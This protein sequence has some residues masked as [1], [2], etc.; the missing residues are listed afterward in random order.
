MFALNLPPYE[1]NIVVRNG[2]K[3]IFDVLR[4]NFV[5][6]TPEEWVR[7]HFIHY[8]LDSK[9]YP[10][11]LLGNEMS[12]TL[13]G[14]S[15][16]CDSVLWSKDLQPRMI[17]EYKAPTIKITQKTFNQ[18]NAYNSVLQVPYI[19]A[20]NGIVHY[21]CHLD[22]AKNTCEFLSQIPDYLDLEK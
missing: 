14:M 21:C 2:Q 17:I 13:N 5:A 3:M 19:I 7:Q 1:T 22:K 11:S 18:I 12:I 20:S 9:G 15:R 6:L 8:L 10:S 4:R 16:R